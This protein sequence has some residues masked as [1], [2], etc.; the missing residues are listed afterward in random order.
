MY[1]S[2]TLHQYGNNAFPLQQHPTN[3]AAA[4]FNSQQREY[5]QSVLMTPSSINSAVK[6]GSNT[7]VGGKVAQQLAP[8]VRNNP[9]PAYGSSSLSAMNQQTNIGTPQ[10]QIARP[11]SGAPSP[12]TVFIPVVDQSRQPSQ[13]S[14]TPLVNQTLNRAQT[15][16]YA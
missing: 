13:Q 10:F 2:H 15:A 16:T 8:T 11:Q 4:A 1:S 7:G 9:L 12:Q 3:P 14:Q 6:P 5:Q